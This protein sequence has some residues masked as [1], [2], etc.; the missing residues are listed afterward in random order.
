MRRKYYIITAC[1]ILILVG[2]MVFTP[3]QAHA[4]A[5]A[6]ASLFGFNLWDFIAEMLAILVQWMLSI[7]GLWVAL[8]GALLNVSIVLTLHIKD[9][10]NSVSGVYLVWQTIRDLSGL[11]IIFMLLYASFKIILGF[12]TVGAAGTLIKNIVIAGILINFSFFITSLLIDAS[13]IVSLAF[14]NGIVAAPISGQNT[15]LKPKTI[16]EESMKSTSDGGLSGIFMKYIVPQSIY[17]PDTIKL[18]QS[19][20]T[21][22][23]VSKPL[24]IVIQGIVGAVVMFTSG[25]SFLLAALA[26]VARLAI[27]I[28][29]LAFSPIWFAARIFPILEPK[30]KEF[31]NHLYSQLVFMPIYLLLLYA[32][33]RVLS[34][35]TIFTNPTTNVFQGGLSTT[36]WTNLMVLAINDF[37]ILF[38]LNMPL[39]I[40]FSYGGM[41]T[42]FLKKSVDKFGAKNVWKNVGSFTGRRTLGRAAYAANESGAMKRL[43][44]LS[45]TLGGFASKGLSSVSGAGFGVKKGGYKDV[46]DAKKKAEEA[47]HK[48]IGNVERGD[49][50]TKEE[51]DKAKDRARA[52]QEKYRANLP[53]KSGVMGFMLDNRAN[54]QT[55]AK[56]TEEV[57]KKAAKKDLQKNRDLKKTLE[58]KIAEKEADMEKGSRVIGFQPGKPPTAQDLETVKKW[59]E[60]LSNVE[61]K[62]DDGEEEAE[63]ERIEKTAKAIEREAKEDKD[64]GWG[65]GEKPKEEPK[66]P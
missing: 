62:I 49:Y 64:R 23:G 55:S 19:D 7:M 58:Q 43:A 22:S 27:L 47:M 59:K 65:G 15:D 28:I 37:F 8:T 36:V 1:A 25:M 60:E 54:R 24:E 33:L 9:F 57:R 12:D 50:A 30:A 52:Y 38:L 42:D 56:L 6:I 39:V 13:N 17:S 10:V 46:L 40:A 26:F 61:Q 32:A 2:M 31:W 11:F 21:S 3:Q 29:L 66:K 20:Q 35:S 4:Q 51:Y 5:G 34:S 63:N 18:S 48:K 14:Y 41:A 45:P 53:W 16:V 44:S